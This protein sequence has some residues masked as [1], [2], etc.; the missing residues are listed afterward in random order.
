MADKTTGK[1]IL[2]GAGPGDPGLITVRG[3]DAVMNAEVLIYDYLANP[4]F[5]ADSKAKEKIYV[6]KT[7]AAHTMEQEDINELIVKKALEGNLV[8]RLKGGDPY[9]FGRGSEEASLCVQRGVPVE[10]IPGIPAALG[11]GA[12]A[13]VPLTDRRF[14]SAVM[15]I[16]GHEDPT[17]ETSSIEWNHLANCK[18]TLV[19]Y[20][21]VKNLPNIASKLQ[22]NGMSA[23]TPVAI[24]EW[25]TTPR[26]RT[27]TATLGTAA[28][29][30][31]EKNV[32]APAL[33]IVGGVASLHEELGWFQKQ[34]LFGITIAVTRTRA[35]ASGLVK[36]LRALGANVIETPTIAIVPPESWEP[37]DAQ[38]A[39]I[40]NF[41]WIIFTSP[42]AVDSFMSR[43]D[44]SGKDARAL[45]NVLI[46][47]IG[48]ATRDK[49]K[50]YGV[51]A[52]FKPEKYIGESVAQGLIDEFGVAGKKFLLP[53]SAIA[54]TDM[55]DI[56]KKAGA[57]LTEVAAYRTELPDTD[58]TPLKQ[59]I[60]DGNVT[61]VTF[62]SSSTAT[63]F[64]ELLGADFVKDNAR[65]FKG[66]SIGPVT[67]G[68]MREHGIEP[69]VEAGEYTIPG[70]VQAI[71]KAEGK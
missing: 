66:A 18:A 43:L 35:Q 27:V 28:A 65:L 41:D 36:S 45:A 7:G 14:T 33:T 12:Y 31:K 25:A 51:R 68:T 16:T 56:L 4:E 64:A 11:A 48:P 6:G 61:Y 2:V 15:M 13:G 8:V 3:R 26:M 57:E 39:N 58:V 67:S 44:N 46:A 49:L 5:A 70:L 10:V 55:P 50:E 32:K 53:R 17:K 37:L 21:G 30:A 38:I 69:A 47:A 40:S 71:L 22:E 23:D 20:M 29:V 9:M 1:V 24:V 52:D 60:I 34:P 42:N 62:T 54:R 59:A 19:F 63:H